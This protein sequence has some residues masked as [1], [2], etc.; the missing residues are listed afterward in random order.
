MCGN[1]ETMLFWQALILLWISEP[2]PCHSELYLKRTS[3][4]QP[5][6]ILQHFSVNDGKLLSRHKRGWMWN[7][8]FL[9]EEYTGLD[10]Q[11]VGK[12]RY[13]LVFSYIQE[14]NKRARAEQE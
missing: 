6:Q 2:N 13:M 3:D 7:Q 14:F 10:Y 8:F 12:V 11:Y 5:Q 9:L 4:D 1:T